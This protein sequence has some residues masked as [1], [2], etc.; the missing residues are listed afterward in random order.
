MDAGTAYGGRGQNWRSRNTHVNSSSASLIGAKTPQM[1]SWMSPYGASG[2]GSHGDVTHFW[3]DFQCNCWSSPF[4][5][6]SGSYSGRPEIH[7]LAVLLLYNQTDKGTGKSKSAAT[8]HSSQL[9]HDQ[10][11]SKKWEH[12][13]SSQHMCFSAPRYRKKSSEK[14]GMNMN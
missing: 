14:N 13:P 3:D 1:L 12:V 9:Q 10:E 6:L 8:L 4:L 11:E 5:Y 2:G 7:S